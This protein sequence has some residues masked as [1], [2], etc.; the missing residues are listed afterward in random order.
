MGLGNEKLELKLNWLPNNP[1]QSFFNKK[2]NIY[3]YILNTI[4]EIPFQFHV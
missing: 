4:V 1:I 3:K 2:I